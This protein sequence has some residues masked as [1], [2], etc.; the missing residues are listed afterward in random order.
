MVPSWQKGRFLRQAL[1][2]LVQQTYPHVEVIVQDNDSTDETQTILDEY[3]PRLACIRREKDAGQSD[4]IDRGFRQSNG[5][6]LGWLNADDL[7]MPDALDRVVAAFQT[8]PGPDVVYG[9]CA[10]LSEDGRFIRYFHEIQ[11]F[12]APVLLNRMNYIAQSSTFYTRIAYEQVGGVDRDL[13][14]VMDWD[15]WSRFAKAGYRFRLLDE[16]LSGARYYSTTKTEEG[17][18]R[19]QAEILRV[20]RRNKTSWLPLAAA[21]HFYGDVIRPRVAFLH[22]PA[23]RLWRVLTGRRF[24]APT[25]IM[26]MVYPDRI[27][28]SEVSLR[29]PCYAELLGVR[30]ELGYTGSEPP[31]SGIRARI[32]AQPGDV[33]YA[34]GTVVIQWQFAHLSYMA[35]IQCDIALDGFRPDTTS[36]GLKGITLIHGTRPS[37]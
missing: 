7:L 14:Y 6:I 12:S 24:H 9:H 18:L 28:L 10:L 31:F 22:P 21:A 25:P 37:T 20:N 35:S 23:R 36:L 16:V 30:V 32:G 2:S 26:G 4:A 11:P 19:R 15:L 33:H 3:G 8:E 5:D 34:E 29:F 27:F 1:D 13:H 17:G